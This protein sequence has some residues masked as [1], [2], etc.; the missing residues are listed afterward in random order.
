ML[1]Y[2]IYEDEN[3]KWIDNKNWCDLL[4]PYFMDDNEKLHEKVY[5]CPI[6][7]TG[8]CS[9]AMNKNIPADANE[10]PG[11]FVLLFESVPGWSQTGGADDV[12]TNRHGEKN[13]GANIA[14]ADGRVEFVKSEDIPTLRWTVE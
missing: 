7:K 5:L 14:F 8:P 11:D 4:K 6:D 12:V 3:D 13:P 9:Y 1:T 2:Y 10:L